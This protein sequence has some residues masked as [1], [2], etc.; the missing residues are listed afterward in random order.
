M[1]L[2]VQVFSSN[3]VGNR[4]ERDVVLWIPSVVDSQMQPGLDSEVRPLKTAKLAVGVVGLGLSQEV[5]QDQYSYECNQCSSE[6]FIVFIPC[7]IVSPSTF[8]S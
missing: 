8:I 7:L 3:S 2:C 6:S 4:A 5:R 1:S